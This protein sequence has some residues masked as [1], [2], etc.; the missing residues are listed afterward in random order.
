MDIAGR[1]SIPNLN[2]EIPHYHP[3]V[4][5]KVIIGEPCIENPCSYDAVQNVLQHNKA[6]FKIDGTRNGQ[7]S[8]VMDFHVF[9][10]RVS[11]RNQ[12]IL[13]TFY[14]NLD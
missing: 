12:M 4:P 3:D 13:K 7:Q 9:W 14:F 5:P 8:A 10:G 11:L 1:F 6:Q 2:E